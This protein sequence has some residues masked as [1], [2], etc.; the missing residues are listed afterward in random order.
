[1]YTGTEVFTVAKKSLRNKL[2]NEV[3]QNF[4]LVGGTEYIS[5]Y[6]YRYRCS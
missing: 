1:V 3:S 4:G 2:T 5:L 6:R